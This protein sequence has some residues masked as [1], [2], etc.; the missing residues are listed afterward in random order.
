MSN[1]DLSILLNSILCVDGYKV[2]RF[3]E[4]MNDHP[5]QIKLA[6]SQWQSH[7]EIHANI[8]PLPI[9]NTQWLQQLSGFHVIGLGLMT[10]NIF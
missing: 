9:R 3:G 1:V 6:G 5:N 7:N 2:S 10:G 8:I 4:S